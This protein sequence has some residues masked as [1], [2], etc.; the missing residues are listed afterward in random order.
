MTERDAS[1]GQPVDDGSVLPGETRH[2]RRAA[3]AS[4]DA[5]PEHRA[6][7]EGREL[8]VRARDREALTAYRALAE[9][10]PAEAADGAR[11]E[12]PT[13]RTLRIQRAGASSSSAATPGSTADLPAQGPTLHPASAAHP[14]TAT[15][16]TDRVALPGGRRDRRRQE[17]ART[18]AVVPQGTAVDGSSRSAD[19]DT[20]AASPGAPMADRSAT[21]PNGNMTVEEALAARNAL[22]QDARALVKGL[23]TTDGDGGIVV[24]LEILAQQKALAERAAVLNARA[25]RIQELAEQNQQRKAVPN[26]PTTAHN[27]PF[28]PHSDASRRPGDAP[29]A[30]RAPRTSHIPVVVPR[31]RAADPGPDP[32]SGTADAPPPEREATRGTGPI[33]ARTAFGL[34]PLDA[35]T[36]GLG[37]ARRLRILQ[38]SLLGVGGAALVTGIMMTVSSLN[39]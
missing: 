34:D 11:V 27:I 30:L 17:T 7:P 38:Y 8:Q 2:S 12:V 23:E 13:R 18:A 25:R 6:H 20:P 28:V 35:M 10:R 3:I 9:G 15:G 36:A 37:R 1:G 22:V 21:W 39:G 5:V 26:D 29:S 24:D 33:G 32:G 16:S 4:V 14:G 31:A 19:D